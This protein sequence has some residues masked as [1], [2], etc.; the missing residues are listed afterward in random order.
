MLSMQLML[1]F[2]ILLLYFVC[3]RNGLLDFDF[4]GISLGIFSLIVVLINSKLFIS[5]IGYILSIESSQITIIIVLF[6]FLF[7]ISLLTAILFNRMKMNQIEL[8]IKIALIDLSE[9]KEKIND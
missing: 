7:L 8:F 2:I 3:L 5:Y 9:K 6:G 1:S 4:L